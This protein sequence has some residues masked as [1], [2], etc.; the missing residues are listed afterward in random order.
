MKFPIICL[1]SKLIWKV[2]PLPQHAIRKKQ[3]TLTSQKIWHPRGWNIGATGAHFSSACQP[4]WAGRGGFFPWGPCGAM[5]W[6]AAERVEMDNHRCL[7]SR[8]LTWP[9]KMGLPKWEVVFQPSSFMCY[10]SFREG[11][12]WQL[13][14]TQTCFLIFTPISGEMIQFDEHI[15]F[16]W[17]GSTAI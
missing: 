4:F 15:F 11:N 17:V 13:K 5:N 8:K 9:L 1:I 16:R 6:M 14:H 2:F 7:H 3:P 12:K 10:V